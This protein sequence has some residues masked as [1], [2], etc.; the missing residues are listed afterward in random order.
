MAMNDQ[1]SS[2]NKPSARP[3][4]LGWRL[5]A[6]IYDSLPMIPLVMLTSALMVWLHGGRTV[7][8]S[9]G[10]AWLQLL[11]MWGLVGLYFVFSWRRGGQTMGMRPW[12]L[13]VLAADGRPAN[14]SSLWLR[15]LVATLT[16]AL[17]LLWCMFDE[18]RRGLHD[19]AGGTVFVR[20]EPQPKP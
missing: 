16:P 8:N 7:E 10:F 9:L 5:L 14:L 6:L 12:R 4:R 17:C 13:R 19:L 1:A 3:A 20:M 15:Y 18:R 2:S 11:T